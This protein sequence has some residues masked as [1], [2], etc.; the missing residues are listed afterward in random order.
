ME[1]Q[2]VGVYALALIGVFAGLWMLILLFVAHF[3]RLE[4][5][6]QGMRPLVMGWRAFACRP[7]FGPT[8][9]VLYA[10]SKGVIHSADCSL[11]NWRTPLVFDKDRIIGDQ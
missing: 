8:F 2:E 9:R 10:D 11:R 6:K 3:I 7:I 4:L 5:Q 1:V